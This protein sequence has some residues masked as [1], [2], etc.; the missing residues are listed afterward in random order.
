MVPRDQMRMEKK[1]RKR[2]TEDR[3]WRAPISRQ[4]RRKINTQ[5]Y[6]DC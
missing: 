2:K 1:E 6:P 4:N 5:S 3:A